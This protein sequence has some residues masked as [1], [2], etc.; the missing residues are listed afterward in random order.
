[1]SCRSQ[2]RINL[3]PLNLEWKWWN[4]TAIS[5]GERNRSPLKDLS[6]LRE[7]SY[8]RRFKNEIRCNLVSFSYINDDDSI[9]RQINE[10]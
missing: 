4:H 10:R 7:K 5:F 1:M 8:I 6:Q 9:S 3:A 2:A